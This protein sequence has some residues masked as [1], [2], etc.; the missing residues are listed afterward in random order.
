VRTCNQCNTS[1]EDGHRFCPSCGFPIGA[2]RPASG[3]PL[4]GRTLGG[5]YTILEAIG[6]GGMGRV[7][8]AEQVSLGKTLAIK[9][10][11]PH[12]AGDDNAVARFYAEARACSRIN[13]PNAVSVLDF[14]RTD[15]NLLYLVMEYIR[16]RDLSRIVWEARALPWARGAEIIRQVLAALS[17]AHEQHVIHRDIKPENVLVEPLRT[18]GDFVKVVDFG[19]AKIRSDTAPGVTSPGLVC[20]TP[21]YMA[22]EQGRGLPPDP[23]SDLYSA[24]V[25]LYYCV[26]GRL[27]FEAE[28]PQQVLLKHVNEPP[29]DPREF[30][31]GLP[32]HFVAVLLRGLEKD[33]D[34][35]YATAVD[36]AEAL[37]GTLAAHR[38]D[39]RV[40]R[41]PSCGA[42]VSAG[43]RFC[44]ECGARVVPAR[45]SDETGAHA[46]RRPRFKVSS[47]TSGLG[48]LPM[49]GRQ[50][51]LR[52][53][54]ELWQ[55]A[56]TGALTVASLTG[57]EGVGRHRLL[58]AV[59]AEV[60]R[61]GGAAVS[62][63]PDPTWAGVA[64]A[65]VG[66]CVR[67]LLGV[68]AGD[69]PVAWFD[70]RFPP[71][72][73]EHDVVARAG[74]VEIFVPG[75]A[76]ELDARSRTAAAVRALELALAECRRVC[77]QS[78]FIAWEQLQRIDDASVRVL[79]AFLARPRASAACMVFSFT[80][81]YQGQWV[82]GHAVALRGLTLAQAR[83]VALNARPLHPPEE[84]IEGLPEEVLPLHL[85]Q[86]LRWHLEGGGAAP[87]RL[88]DLI[89][90][91]LDR[92]SM[93]AR[94]V[95]QALA[96]LG[97]A[98]PAVV[99]RVVGA[100][101]DVSTA[102]VLAERGWIVVEEREPDQH[103]SIAHALL[104]EVV[105]VS[106]PYS[107]RREIHASCAE[108]AEAAKAPDE[109][110]ALHSEYTP[111]TFRT[112]LLLERV[113]DLCLA[114]GD[115]TAA[116]QALRRG[117]DFARREFAL[118]DT[119]SEGAVA[120]FTRKLGDAL[121]R[122][123]DFAE[124]EGV[125]REGVALT[126]HGTVEWA[127]LQGALGR[128]LSARGRQSEGLRA[129]DS[130]VAVATRLGNPGL[131]SELLVT[132]AELESIAREHLDAVRSLELADARIR[133]ALRLA[134]GAPDALL[135]QR[136]EL[137]VRLARAR[138]L[139]GL[140]GE[141]VIAEARPLADSLNLGRL[142]AR[143]EEELAERAEALGDRRTAISAWQLA[144][145]EARSAGDAS[146]EAQ[147]AERARILGDPK[148][149]S[150]HPR[151]T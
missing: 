106:I 144:A 8:R 19:L 38:R 49:V 84:A 71:E 124:A 10:I 22:P 128:A 53:L 112:L 83:E 61:G 73:G 23:R 103:I 104:R 29:P 117:L 37:Q 9:V 30:V 54:V 27:P 133:D 132:R 51:Q 99:A 80:P 81:R 136:A 125:L 111:V 105:D 66:R 126:T 78:P 45:G 15:D 121:G 7:Y 32:D 1:C 87:E 95:L 50:A 4:I 31:K 67:S 52:R 92:L 116:A 13:H 3:D 65:A 58:Q 122:A 89:S 150:A 6:A 35:R 64:Y 146:L 39:D 56:T 44:G 5:G 60:A 119:D 75:G 148:N 140:D 123:G 90:A 77:G 57:E 134:G 63:L 41:C 143:C 20:G 46:E 36:F 110:L 147:Y 47:S 43:L 88:V 113:G 118:G 24:A 33:P 70:A 76:P 135:R 130:A 28:L 141:K 69:D 107:L 59:M 79:A 91:R 82:G 149:S 34:V 26:T 102:R 18:G 21:D 101:G 48:A 108:L 42:A 86:R 74:M 25:V 114:R 129:I 131:V 97:E 2:L 145:H 85:E 16:G 151:T 142:L 12:L 17:E 93:K 72:E 138:R 40:V 96:V 115:D 120:I 139:A 127:R 68:Q 137:L 62:V 109:V 94:R 11:H 14:G 98:T 55:E 100:G